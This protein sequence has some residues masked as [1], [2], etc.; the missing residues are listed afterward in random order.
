MFVLLALA[1]ASCEKPSLDSSTDVE[2]VPEAGY[3][4]F[5]TGVATKAPMIENLRG[6]SFG[7]FGYTYGYSTKWENAK[8]LARPQLFYNQEVACSGEGVCTYD[9]NS[10]VEGNQLKPWDLSQKYSFFAYY[11]MAAQG[12][13]IS[14]SGVN[15]VG[16]PTVTYALPLVTNTAGEVNPD[17]LQDLMTGYAVDKTAGDGKVGFIFQHRLFCIE[18]LSQNFNTTKMV[19]VKNENGQETEV[20]IDADETISDLTLTIDN[21]AYESITVPMMKGDS[22]PSTV[23]NSKGPVIFRL[24]SSDESVKVPSQDEGGGAVSLSGDKYIMLIPQD[25]RQTELTGELSYKVTDSRGTTTLET[26]EFKSDL[27][28]EEGKKY[29]MVLSFTGKTV[30]IATAKAGSWETHPV[31]HEFE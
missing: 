25:A 16:M 17:A 4:R 5:S 18:V 31:N 8:A 7:V 11:P 3:I 13:G 28:F 15:A 2:L 29:N 30:I 10:S 23:L 9:I 22:A 20:E 19:K 6:K 26:C 24:L 27:N 21:L 14:T 1:I 12:N